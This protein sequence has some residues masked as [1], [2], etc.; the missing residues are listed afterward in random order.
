[1][2]DNNRVPKLLVYFY[3]PSN[4]LPLQGLGHIE[5]LYICIR[6]RSYVLKRQIK[7]GFSKCK[8]K[9]FV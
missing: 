9:R 7:C 3:V 2:P 8:M 1:M 5:E 4:V 6:L